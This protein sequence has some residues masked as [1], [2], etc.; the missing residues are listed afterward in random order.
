MKNLPCPN[1]GSEVDPSEAQIFAGVFCCPR[2]FTSAARLD[3]RMT[4]ELDA[5]KL[6]GR[7]AIRISLA[8]G[9][10]HFGEQKVEDMNKTELLRAIVQIQE[11]E[12]ARRKRQPSASPV[13][14]PVIGSKYAGP[15]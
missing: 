14:P 12:E 9:K 4:R 6:M 8:T 7:E 15:R 11:A 1:C 10:L 2:C 13:L 5:L 3:E